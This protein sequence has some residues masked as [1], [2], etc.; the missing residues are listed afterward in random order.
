MKKLYDKLWAKISAF[1]LLTVFLALTV[2]GS[3]GIAWL[4]CENAYLDGGK[5]AQEQIYAN[6]CFADLYDAYEYL[7]NYAY[8]PDADAQKW[9]SDFSA[10]YPAEDCSTAIIIRDAKTNKELARNFDPAKQP[11]FEKELADTVMFNGNRVTIT[12]YLRPDFTADRYEVRLEIWLIQHAYDIIALTAVCL[13]L[14]VIFLIF[15]LCSAG[16]WPGHEGIHL[17]WFDKIPL[18]LYLIFCCCF[19]G[20]IFDGAFEVALICSILL[21]LFLLLLLPSF[22]A[23]CK[24][25]TLF[26]STVIGWCFKWLRRLLK[27]LM[28]VIADIPMVWK[29]AVGVAAWLGVNLLCIVN[30]YEGEFRILLLLVNLLAGLFLIYLALGL[31]K[32]QKGGEA[33]AAG[34][35]DTAVDT[36]HLFGDFKRHGENLNDV[37]QGVQKAVEARMRSERLKTELITNVSHDIK[38]PLTSIVNYVDLLKKEDIDNPAAQEY[39]AVLERQSNRLR[40]LTEDLIEASK[41]ATGNIAAE[42][43]PTDVGVLLEQVLGEYQQRLDSS[44]ITPMLTLPEKP[45]SI[46]ADGRLLWRVLDNLLSNVC[47]YA[48]PGTRVY[49][50]TET[51]SVLKEDTVGSKA[52]ITVKNISRCPLNISADELTERFVRG[53]E[54]RSTE[55]SGL[56]LSIASSLT[57]LQGGQFALAVDGDLFKATLTFDMA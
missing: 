12:G 44:Q 46:M 57:A 43:S 25:G 30:Y 4:A 6:I 2:A 36:A 10:M 39:I 7:G 56:G 19:L 16:H 34:H 26:R 24:T 27:W 22:A 5:Q 35:Y 47:K 50:S 21:G 45:I 53:D 54:S 18:D 38:T 9:L 20:G 48:M 40:R 29:T 15:T 55:G 49:L 28:G 42:L 1:V 23:R 13:V 41:A 3:I 31:R 8:N 51:H 52:V 37:Q 33:L 32:L 11:L 14:T 17:T